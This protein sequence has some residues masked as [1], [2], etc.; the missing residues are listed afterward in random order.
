MNKG[1][2]D[3]RGCPR[4]ISPLQAAACPP[5]PPAKPPCLDRLHHG[6]VEPPPVP[7]IPERPCCPSAWPMHRPRAPRSHEATPAPGPADPGLLTLL[8]CW[9]RSPWGDPASDPVSFAPAT[10]RPACRSSCW[11]AQ[12]LVSPSSHRWEHARL[13]RNQP[14]ADDLPAFLLARPRNTPAGTPPGCWCCAL[15][16]RREQPEP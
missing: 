16:G 8:G 10:P 2:E 14:Q 5:A 9:P 11:F 13:G 15:R 1:L 6:V 7:H 3:R 12:C 4:L